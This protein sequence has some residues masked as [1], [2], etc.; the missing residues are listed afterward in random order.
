VE[1]FP[2]A[3]DMQLETE[4]L[5]TLLEKV[6]VRLTM[7][8]NCHHEETFLWLASFLEEMAFL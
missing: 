6:D 8:C 4:L 1:E 3:F 5:D 2:E 7:S